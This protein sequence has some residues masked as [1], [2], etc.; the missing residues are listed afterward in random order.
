ME[1]FTREL[2]SLILDL[3]NT[4]TKNTNLLSEFNSIL[5]T[6]KRS[7]TQ[8]NYYQNSSKKGGKYKKIRDMVINTHIRISEDRKDRMWQKQYL[9]K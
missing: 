6:E 9:K 1:N 5:G 2:K 8:K 4:A 3:E 7:V